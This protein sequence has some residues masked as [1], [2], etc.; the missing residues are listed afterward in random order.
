MRVE[1]KA[2]STA[3]TTG[4]YTGVEER[5]LSSG[6]TFGHYLSRTVN[7]LNCY[8]FRK[9]SS[10][11][12][13]IT[14]STASHGQSFGYRSFFFHSS[15]LRDRMRIHSFFGDSFVSLNLS[16]RYS[17]LQGDSGVGRWRCPVLWKTHCLPI[18]FW[19]ND[20]WAHAL[21][22]LRIWCRSTPNGHCPDA[23]QF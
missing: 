2:E 7:F 9:E 14:T 12:E 4:N 5:W 6:H 17:E 13:R 22:A 10:A 8:V 11:P 1:W 23:I 3:A 15:P 18:T 20:I 19:F 16:P 21:K